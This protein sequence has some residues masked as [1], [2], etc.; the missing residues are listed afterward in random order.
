M[1]ITG[2]QRRLV[3]IKPA[4]WGTSGTDFLRKDCSTILLN[5]ILTLRLCILISEELRKE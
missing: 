3:H 1:K 4:L 5:P 2:E